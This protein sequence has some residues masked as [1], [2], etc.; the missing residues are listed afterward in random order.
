M[1]VCR[2]CGVDFSAEFPDILTCDCCYDYDPCLP[3]LGYDTVRYDFDD[4]TPT[5]PPQ[6]PTHPQTPGP[7]TLA[8]QGDGPGAAQPK[9]TV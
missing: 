8:Q 4:S 1:S 6:P 5:Q 7:S 9:E 2:Q 3:T